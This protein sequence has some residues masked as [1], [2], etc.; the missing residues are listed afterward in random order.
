MIADTVGISGFLCF[1]VFL[2][3]LMWSFIWWMDNYDCTDPTLLAVIAITWL[4]FN[5]FIIGCCMT[6]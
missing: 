3:Y 6:L 2:G 1:C 4:L 5:V